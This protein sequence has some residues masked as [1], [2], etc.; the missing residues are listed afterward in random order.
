[1]QE[2]PRD[3][4]AIVE[5]AVQALRARGRSQ[6]SLKF[7]GFE[8]MM[9]N[10]DRRRR[11]R[12]RVRVAVGLGVTGVAT[13]LVA[14]LLSARSSETSS[15]PGAPAGAGQVA[16]PAQPST[17]TGPRWMRPS[18]NLAVFAEERTEV[19][20][21]S[22]ERVVLAA[23][24]LVLE[25]RGHQ[26]DASLVIDTPDARVA[27]TG[28]VL[29][30]AT[31]EAGT[32]VEVLRGRVEVTPRGKPAILVGAGQR[33]G[34]GMAA[35]APLPAARAAALAA[36][37]PSIEPTVT[38]STATPEAPVVAAA[39]PADPPPAPPA[40]RTPGR[41]ESVHDGRPSAPPAVAPVA[42]AEE[43]YRL[44]EE[45]LRGRRYAEAREHLEEVLRRVPPGGSSEGM[46]LMDLVGACEQ[47][48]DRPCERASLER[49]L[50]RQPAGAFREQARVRLCRLLE[51]AGS[52]SELRPCLREYVGEFPEGRNVPWAREL[53]DGL[54]ADSPRGDGE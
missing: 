52:V 23:G 45:A 13:I 38:A 5:E 47:L 16:H 53:L 48:R 7:A 21:P 12:R 10:V 41:A 15:R 46:A 44:A 27:V 17:P 8:K 9:A 19:T 18:T 11:R 51:R 37:F 32:T 49:Y 14:L 29:S 20:F 30:V 36:L 43:A 50:A 26:Y 35:P 1:M 54:P 4:M 40:P 28:T 6:P 2:E 22:E 39:V 33:L 3:D 25:F 42:D 31:D 24:R 34:P